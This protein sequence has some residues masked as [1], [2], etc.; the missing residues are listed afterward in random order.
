MKAA[1]LYLTTSLWEG[2]PRTIIEAFLLGIPVVGSNIGGIKEVVKNEV[3]GFTFDLEYPAEGI[4][5]AVSILNNKKL[6]SK[7]SKGAMANI[8]EEFS[9]TYMLERLAEMY[10]VLG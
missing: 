6:R 4:S 2:L 10:D 9:K 7:L 1:D 5:H 8:P 3:N